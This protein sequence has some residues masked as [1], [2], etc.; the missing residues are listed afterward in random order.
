M[1]LWERE[2]GEGDDFVVGYADGVQE[3]D[4]EEVVVLDGRLDEPP[5]EAPVV[6]EPAQEPVIVEARP[7]GELQREGPL[8]LRIN[9]PPPPPRAVPAVPDAP[10][11]ARNRRRGMPNRRI[12]RPGAARQGEPIGA[13]FVRG[14]G[15]GAARQ[16]AVIQAREAAAQQQEAAHQAW[17]QRFVQMALNDEE[18][19]LEWDSDDE[20]DAAAWEIPVR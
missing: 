5:V 18:D 4:H 19:Q 13:G 11:P 12:P 8:V 9:A 2:A 14:G 20:E 1:R 7:Q 16:E 17:V 15:R 3:I 10:E 6:L